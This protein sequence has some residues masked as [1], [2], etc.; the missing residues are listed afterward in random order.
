MM[1][2]VIFFVTL[3]A[4]SSGYPSGTDEC[5]PPRHTGGSSG[6]SGGLSMTLDSN[7]NVILSSSVSF[8]GFFMRTNTGFAWSNPSVNSKLIHVCGGT[9]TAICHS[10]SNPRTLAKGTINC[11]SNPGASFTV[12][13]YVVYTE[14]SPYDTIVKSFVC[15]SGSS[16][17]TSTTSTT[18]TPNMS[19]STTT[20]TPD[21]TGSGSNG[22]SSLGF[23]RVGW[24]LESSSSDSDEIETE[25]AQTNMQLR[26][27]LDASKKGWAGIGFGYGSYTMTGG[28]KSV[29]LFA[30]NGSCS[31]LYFTLENH[32]ALFF[33]FSNLNDAWSL[34]PECQVSDDM[35]TA[36]MT[37]TIGAETSIP[38]FSSGLDTNLLIA[39]GQG[40]TIGYHGPNIDHRVVDFFYVPT[41]STSSTTTTTPS[42]SSTIPPSPV[43]VG[44]TGSFQS[45]GFID[46][47]W[48]PFVYESS[49][50]RRRLSS[51]TSGGYADVQIYFNLQSATYGWMGI[52]FGYAD[53]VM[54]GDKKAIVLSK[55]S[56][57][58][59]SVKFYL[60]TAHVAIEASGA[61]PWSM[62]PSCSTLSSSL[63]SLTFRVGG[64][65]GIV[66]PN[67]GT[68]GMYVLLAGALN[69]TIAEGHGP[70]GREYKMIDFLTTES[71]AGP[72]RATNPY[73]LWHG[74]LFII[75]FAI[76]MPVTCFLILTDK[77]RFLSL[78]KYLGVLI[79]ILLGIGWILTSQGAQAKRDGTYADFASNE[80]GITHKQYGAAG[81]WIAAVVCAGG[82]LLWWIRLPTRM[83]VY[84]R[85]AHGAVG[86]A[87]SFFGPY[88]VWTGWVQLM[89]VIPVIAGL[90]D[91]A[92][93][94]YSVAISLL[95]VFAGLFVLELKRHRVVKHESS[96]RLITQPEIDQ[97]V[98]EGKLIVVVDGIVCE[99][100]PDFKH[101]GG[102]TVLEKLNGKEVGAI[103]R[104]GTV[105]E[106]DGRIRS[107][108]H[109]ASAFKYATKMA[110]GRIHFTDSIEMSNMAVPV[111]SAPVED[112]VLFGKVVSMNQVNQSADFP[113][114]LFKIAL[115]SDCAEAC[116]GSRIFISLTAADGSVLERPYTV[117]ASEGRTIEFCIKIYPEGAMTSRLNR[118][119]PGQTVTLSK[120]V[121][122]SAIPSVPK[123]PL[124]VVFVAG[125]T[126]VTPMISY[127]KECAKI[128]LG[129]H[130][131]WWVRNEGDL[132]LV[133]EIELW[134]RQYNVRIQVFFTQ[135]LG[136][137]TSGLS[138]T[139]K[140]GKI[141]SAC[142]LDVFG[143]SLPVGVGEVA[144]VM[145]GPP[146]FVN[147]AH[148]SIRDLG[149]K[150]NRV[151]SL[152]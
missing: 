122:H 84:V 43:P 26:L 142:I 98:Q 86:I 58:S 10:N 88:V 121:A 6:S 136:G 106:I 80:I 27:T 95:V 139:P 22:F 137:G 127:F 62:T 42:A 29:V 141:S 105:F 8:K 99:I 87:L 133:K 55:D 16:S 78:H 77:V 140:T 130:L 120:P 50:R 85:Y 17:S 68:G 148:L 74:I 14:R 56:S 25:D 89:P 48:T 102:R 19:G 109:S 129:G 52:G 44:G 53:G 54:D 45:L 101:P 11:G 2:L 15:P 103:M 41:T 35:L 97:M 146:G 135:P 23:V 124:L 81:C 9:N 118:L 37:F 115:D 38:L 36:T 90:T 13:A 71:P 57:G 143:G 34:S 12:T 116:V 28:K 67:Q 91:T 4:L 70:S 5:G 3:I 1:K 18:T 149:A 128:A 117:C 40:V 30:D 112:E 110:I 100:P 39:G 79:V 65:S 134:G 147:A 113:V 83:K 66:L 24:S 94:W 144:W 132:F 69:A 104:G 64:D 125:G 63:V 20:T 46:F 75:N 51:S 59:C 93:A 107:Y 119:K 60:L 145:S 114:R 152:D 123:P 33:G 126:G 31:V 61:D 49:S 96:M 72:T 151:L 111:A 92:W 21:P 7:N 73:Y 82:V 131:L 76:L 138:A 108:H 32:Q 150:G 47:E